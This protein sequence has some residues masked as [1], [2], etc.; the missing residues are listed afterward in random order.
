M[1]SPAG[2]PGPAPGRQYER[3]D[4][5]LEDGGLYAVRSVTG[6]SSRVT[7]YT[8]RELLEIRDQVSALEAAAPEALITGG[9]GEFT[10]TASGKPGTGVV[11]RRQ[12]AALPPG[13]GSGD[14]PVPARD[15]AW[16]DAQVAAGGCLRTGPW[17]WADGRWTAPVREITVPADAQIRR[18]E[19]PGPLTV[20]EAVREAAAGTMLIVTQVDRDGE[21]VL[22]V[23]AAVWPADIVPA[24]AGDGPP[25]RGAL[26]GLPDTVSPWPPGAAR[27]R[28]ACYAVAADIAEAATLYAAAVPARHTGAS[29][30]DPLIRGREEGGR[31]L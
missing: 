25:G 29:R 20:E 5:V 6:E 4:V 22:G 9:A 26:A 19:H 23:R 2:T 21:P 31:D 15:L 8:F 17:A 10:A 18:G 11:L 16:L 1:S 24:A 14:G 12:S 13:P 7:R 3:T 30:R 27:A 28:I